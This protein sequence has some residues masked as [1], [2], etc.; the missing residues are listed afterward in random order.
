MLAGHKAKTA[1]LP[2]P[3]ASEEYGRDRSV[4]IFPVEKKGMYCCKDEPLKNTESFVLV[5]PGE[6]KAEVGRNEQFP[7][8]ANRFLEKI[9]IAEWSKLHYSQKVL[10]SIYSVI[11][12]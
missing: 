12:M 7:A 2:F 6:N 1:L 3:N 11:S 10:V 8:N 4:D 9:M 5:N